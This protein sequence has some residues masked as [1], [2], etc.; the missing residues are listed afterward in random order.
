MVTAALIFAI[1]SLFICVP[2]MY[3]SLMAR[4]VPVVGLAVMLTFGFL[5]VTFLAERHDIVAA[6]A[7]YMISVNAKDGHE[8]D[9]YYDP[10]D[11]Q[12]FAVIPDDWNI[13]NMYHKQVLDYETTR[14][15]VFYVNQVETINILQTGEGA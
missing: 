3:K 13:I 15:Y 7:E 4:K 8:I 12:Y 10:D 2:I 6:D 11:D 1:A 9:V 5:F 14:D